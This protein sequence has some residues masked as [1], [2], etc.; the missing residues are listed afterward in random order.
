MSA[1]LQQIYK[2]LIKKTDYTEDIEMTDFPWSKLPTEQKKK[3]ILNYMKKHNIQGHISD[4]T[5]K[6]ISFNQERK[7]IINLTYYKK[8]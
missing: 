8:K 3:Y 1:I 2:D 5:F 7:E 6:N 4:Y